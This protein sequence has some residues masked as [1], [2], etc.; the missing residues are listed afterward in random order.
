MGE[1]LLDSLWVLISAC[2]VFFMHAGF[3]LLESGLCRKKN[4]VMIL[5]KNFSVVA[6]ASLLYF[7]LGFALMFGDGNAI[8]GLSAFMPSGNETLGAV[9]QNMPLFVFLF[10]Q[11]VFAAT[12]ATIVSGAVAER[13]KLSTF[14]IF[15]AFASAVIYPLVGHWVWG[16]GFL[17]T[18]GFHDFAGSTVVHAVGGAMALAGV[19]LLGPRRGKFSPDGSPR[20]LPA[21]NLPLAALGVFILWLGWFGFNGGSTLSANVHDIASV[22]VVTNLAAAAGF[23]TALAFVRFRIGMLDLSM[24]MNGALAGLV[25]ITAGA[26]VISPRDA[27]AVGLIAGFVVV[28]GVF[29]LDRLHLDDP[30]GAIPVHLVCG[31]FGTLAVGVFSQDGGLLYGGGFKLLAIQLAGVSTAVFFAF[32][33]GY[34]LWAVMKKTIGIRVSVSEEIEGLDEAECGMQAY[35]EELR[36]HTATPYDSHASSQLGSLR[37]IVTDLPTT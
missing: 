25:A 30:V 10:F 26:D 8:V 21:H 16:G 7:V 9:P 19:M 22:I 33:V 4:A 29:V 34:L 37:Q 32:S 14:F 15:T 11:L 2:L 5:L 18:W 27:I 23:L 6:I 1:G 28:E 13:S 3:A 24:A 36:S 17:S 31:V 12:S 35:G 20:P